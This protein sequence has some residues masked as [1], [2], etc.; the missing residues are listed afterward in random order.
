MMEE[1]KESKINTQDSDSV[2]ILTDDDKI[3]LIGYSVEIDGVVKL[4]EE[5]YDLGHE[6][7]LPEIKKYVKYLMSRD[8]NKSDIFKKVQKIE[9]YKDESYNEREDT[10]D[11]IKNH[12]TIINNWDVFQEYILSCDQL[13]AF[14][15]GVYNEKNVAVK[16]KYINNKGWKIDKICDNENGNDI[17]S[18]L[19]HE[20]EYKFGDPIILIY[21][22]MICRLSSTDDIIKKIPLRSCKQF[23]RLSQRPDYDLI[24]NNNSH[25]QT[26]EFYKW[27]HVERGKSTVINT[28]NTDYKI[29]IGSHPGLSIGVRRTMNIKM[30]WHEN[31]ERDN[32]M[33]K[34]RN[35]SIL[36]LIILFTFGNIIDLD[37]KID[38]DPL[39]ILQSAILAIIGLDVLRKKLDLFSQKVFNEIYQLYFQYDIDKYSIELKTNDLKIKPYAYNGLVVKIKRLFD[40]YLS[41]RNTILKL[42]LSDKLYNEIYLSGQ[43]LS[44]DQYYQKLKIQIL[45]NRR[46]QVIKTV[47]SRRV[48]TDLLLLSLGDQGVFT[49]LTFIIFYALFYDIRSF[50]KCN[51]VW[52]NFKK[53]LSVIMDILS[54]III[55]TLI[56]MMGIIDAFHAFCLSIRD[57]KNYFVLWFSTP[58][59]H[60][61]RMKILNLG[62]SN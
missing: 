8:D 30:L 12:L 27:I 59:F 18:T 9:E 53:G 6:N 52:Y 35:Y 51:R 55:I 10:H 26:Q 58:Q 29:S 4:R 23:E 56:M 14:L 25:I 22:N 24:R 41:V 44:I 60:E 42:C 36:I 19:D 21:Q 31:Y 11:W 57:R 61:E 54:I 45:Q 32:I 1:K 15:G 38:A 3:E 7:Y 28:N 47:D 16:L 33:D 20:T 34:L 2:S 5:V 39:L 17:Q 62:E 37:L 43:I 49:R 50:R 13:T 48:I 46:D 40:F